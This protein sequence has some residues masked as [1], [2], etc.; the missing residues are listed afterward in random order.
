M[1]TQR[2]KSSDQLIPITDP[3]EI[4]RRARAEQRQAQQHAAVSQKVLSTNDPSSANSVSGATE[5]DPLGHRATDGIFVGSAPAA[6][7]S[8]LHSSHTPYPSSPAAPELPND[9]PSAPELPDDQKLPGGT[10][11]E[12]DPPRNPPIG[13]PPTDAKPSETDNHTR[14]GPSPTPNDPPPPPAASNNL[15]TRDCMKMIMSS[16]QASIS[17]AHANQI[18]YAAWLSWA[19]ESNTGQ[20]ARLEDVF[21]TL[22]ENLALTSQPASHPSNQVDHCKLNTLDAPKYTRP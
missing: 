7:P 21:A 1:F 2:T 11:D 10:V 8:G 9:H 19:E 6:L 14:P 17:Q 4:L 12:M 13:N 22:L 5:L 15:S 3:E 18:E 20:T 16:Q